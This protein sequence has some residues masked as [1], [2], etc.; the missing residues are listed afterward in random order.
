MLGQNPDELFD[1]V[2]DQDR[3]VG[4]RPRHEVHRLGLRHRAVHVL[5]FNTRGELFLQQRSLHKDAH[6]G[7]WST[8]CAGHLDAGE[9]YDAA[10][11]RE[12]GEELGLPPERRPALARLFKIRPCRETGQEFVWVYEAHHDGPFD[13]HPGEVAAGAWQDLAA[14]A[15]AI[16]ARPHDFTPALRLILDQLAEQG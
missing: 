9:D 8:S 16:R 3:V 12:L 15:E 11:D 7:R 2:D 14:L 6:P 13:L 4:V 10:A 1:V 5:I